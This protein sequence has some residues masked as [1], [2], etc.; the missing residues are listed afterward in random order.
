MRSRFNLQGS[1]FRCWLGLL[2]V[3]VA[4]VPI[5]VF[6]AQEAGE[7]L[8][9]IGLALYSEQWSENDVVELGDK[10]R[11][12]SRYQVVPMIASNFRSHS[13]RFPIADDAAIL[14]F[15]RTAAA[16]AAPQDV[17]FVHISTHGA[18]YELARRIGEGETTGL[19][20]RELTRI[21]APLA[22]H[23]TIIVISACY[24]G[25]FIRDL[26]GPRRIILTAARADRSSFGCGAGNRHTLFGEA[27]LNAF[28]ESDSSLRQ[29]FTAIRRN[30]AGMERRQ[31]FPASQPQVSVGADVGDLYDAPVF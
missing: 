18:P 20:S 16:Q 27:E 9:Y 10:L 11:E 12:D 19:S 15:V 4:L 5:T 8:F 31:H 14:S 2:S 24:S 1:H 25:S 26:R 21:L 13:G 30:V 7:R 17:I 22:G 3:A 29:I 23:P 28:S 6:A